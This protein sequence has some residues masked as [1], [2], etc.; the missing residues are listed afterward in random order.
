MRETIYT[1]DICNAK[2]YHTWS[3]DHIPEKP[4]WTSYNSLDI[5]VD[6]IP[7]VS[8]AFTLVLKAAKEVPKP[9]PDPRL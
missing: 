8:K 5:C 9:I 4:D 6:C 3:A 2:W 7:L 1:C